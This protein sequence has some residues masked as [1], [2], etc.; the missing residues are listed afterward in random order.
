MAYHLEL[1]PSAE[2]CNG[3]LSAFQLIDVS[4]LS[5]PNIRAFT[6]WY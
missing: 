2:K 1:V 6:I 3:F 5:V 4:S